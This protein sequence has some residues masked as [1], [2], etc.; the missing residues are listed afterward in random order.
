VNIRAPGGDATMGAAY[1][2][3]MPMNEERLIE[4]ET[5]LA[6]QESTLQDLNAVITKQQLRIIEL[7][8]LSRQLMDRV[9]RM[10]QDIFKGSADDEVPPHY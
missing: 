6:Y 1:R 10:G 4:L 8:N 7:E 9:S 3:N 5:R 2:R